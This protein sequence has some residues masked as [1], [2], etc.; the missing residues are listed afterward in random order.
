LSRYHAAY[1]SLDESHFALICKGPSV[2]YATICQSGNSGGALR[3]FDDNKDVEDALQVDQS[4]SSTVKSHFMFLAS[5][6][7]KCEL[8][9]GSNERISVASLG[10]GKNKKNTSRLNCALSFGFHLI[11]TPR[12]H[13][14]WLFPPMEDQ[15]TNKRMKHLT[16]LTT[17]PI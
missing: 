3:L 16:N 2:P 14:Q 11:L 8:E 9:K 13:T 7:A 17:K 10:Q 12:K 5:S 1:L 6:F 4:F 15:A